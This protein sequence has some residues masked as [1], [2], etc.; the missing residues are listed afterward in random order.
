MSFIPHFDDLRDASQSGNT[1]ATANLLADPVSKLLDQINNDPYGGMKPHMVALKEKIVK[2]RRN[3]EA[4]NDAFSDDNIATPL[5]ELRQNKLQQTADETFATVST[6]ASTLAPEEGSKL[7][8]A[9]DM[10]L[11][12]QMG[13]GDALD[14]NGQRIPP[15]SQSVSGGQVTAAPGA[16]PELAAMQQADAQNGP[17]PDAGQEQATRPLPYKI[18][19]D[20]LD[21]STPENQEGI[22]AGFKVAGELLASDMYG[23]EPAQKEF[24]QKYVANL[25]DFL[26]NPSS[27][28][29]ERFAGAMPDEKY[30]KFRDMVIEMANNPPAMAR[31]IALEKPDP[32]WAIAA[33]ALAIMFPSKAG[34]YLAVPYLYAKH[35]Q[36]VKQAYEDNMAAQRFKMWQTGVATFSQLADNQLRADEQARALWQRKGEMNMGFFRDTLREAGDTVQQM[37][38]AET[39]RV[40]AEM[41]QITDGE[42]LAIKT[43]LGNGDLADKQAAW[44]QLD[45]SRRSRGMENPI[46]YPTEKGSKQLQTE[47][48]TNWLNSKKSYQDWKLEADR[49]LQPIVKELKQQQINVSKERVEYMKKV[50]SL[51]ST[52]ISNA[53]IAA[54]ARISELKN[55]ARADKNYVSQM[56]GLSSHI[57]AVARAELASVESEIKQKEDAK[58]TSPKSEQKAIDDRLIQLRD[59][60]T[61]LRATLKQA[62][63]DLTTLQSEMKRQASDRE[64]GRPTPNGASRGG[65]RPQPTPVPDGALPTTVGALKGN[66]DAYKYNGRIPAANLKLIPGTR[67]V[68]QPHVADAMAEMLAAAKADGVNIGVTDGYRSYSAQQSL[69]AS[70]GSLAGTPGRSNHGFGLAFDMDLG[71]GGFDSKEYK[72]LMA[73]AGRFGFAN[74][75]WAQR[76]GSKPEPWHWEYAGS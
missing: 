58:L 31:Q 29:F 15:S 51:R 71:K 66:K 14:A 22:K 55:G 13:G 57:S 25:N 49:E 43:I 35:E 42:N 60:Q 21:H 69:K 62:A 9:V 54:M 38:A 40:V 19:P 23:P 72:W 11:Q 6:L 47:A 48:N 50:L 30:S 75:G 65:T 10:T 7:V 56:S 53:H 1:A 74:P 20:G 73:N 34:Q 45:N 16:D 5:A 33:G 18:G 46:P 76:K 17:Q 12:N 68:A 44:M 32:L 64:G 39:R 27:Y 36:E 4:T 2:F 3:N 28:T 8:Q 67:V 24:A 37:T 59:R 63:E 70:K 41:K 61:D 26:N 52:Q